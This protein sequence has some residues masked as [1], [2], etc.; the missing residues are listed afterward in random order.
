ME[1]AAT[2]VE[3]ELLDLSGMTLEELD[4]GQDVASEINRLLTRVESPPTLGNSSA[5]A[6]EC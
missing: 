6:L 3:T 4:G 2:E 5:G 1:R